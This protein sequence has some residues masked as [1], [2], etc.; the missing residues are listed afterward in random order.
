MEL[1][2]KE[3]FNKLFTYYEPLLTPLQVSYFKMYFMEDLS[4]SEI[5][6]QFKVSRAAIHDQLSKIGKLLEDYEAKLQLLKLSETRLE[7]LEKAIAK[8]DLTVLKKLKEMEL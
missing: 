6:E 5:A 8:N 3:R 7:L 4:L 2:Q 1:I